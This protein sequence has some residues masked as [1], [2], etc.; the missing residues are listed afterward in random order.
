[1]SGL[2]R[3]RCANYCYQQK[4]LGVSAARNVGIASAVGDTILF[5][6]ADDRLHPDSLNRIKDKIQI[7]GHADIIV[8]GFQSTR[9]KGS[10]NDLALLEK[11]P[12]GFSPQQLLSCM[13]DTNF[14]NR[15]YGFVW[16]CAY[17][18][19]FLLENHLCFNR[20]VRVTEDLL[21]LLQ[22]ASAAEHILCIPEALYI[23]QEP[24]PSML[25][26][27]KSYI[28][29]DMH[30]VNQWMIHELCS[31]Y[32]HLQTGCDVFRAETYLCSL[33]NICRPDAPFH[34]FK[35]I[36]TAYKLKKD[37][38]Y[39]PVLFRVLRNIKKL[40]IKRRLVY[41]M[42]LF[43]L[44]PIYILLFTMKQRRLKTKTA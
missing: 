6:D 16:R 26:K 20:Q 10:Q 2:F 39:A 36:C 35:R 17:R 27:Y 29:D 43:D 13:I 33:Q 24:A 14:Q 9:I 21:F 34:F 3:K 18:K 11:N 40:P 15:F 7:S 28:H 44:E 12:N 42:L 32:M 1:M 25:P 19:Q 30:F 22:A 38:A 23:Y 8:F 31:R 37:Y 41:T 5:V 4:N